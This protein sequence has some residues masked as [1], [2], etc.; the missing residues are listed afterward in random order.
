MI[1]QIVGDFTKW[2]SV[3]ISLWKRLRTRR[4]ADFRMLMLVFVLHWPK[5]TVC[6]NSRYVQC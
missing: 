2:H 1:L 6:A 5:Y 3:K 4:K